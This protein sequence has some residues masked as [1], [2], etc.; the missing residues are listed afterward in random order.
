MDA[1]LALEPFASAK[2]PI[3]A[4]TARTF[5]LALLVASETAFRFDLIGGL[6]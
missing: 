1:L 4:L 6:S 2:A 3:F 5:N